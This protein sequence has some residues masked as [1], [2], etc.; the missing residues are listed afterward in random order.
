MV[1][2]Q[3]KFQRQQVYFSSIVKD[4]NQKTKLIKTEAVGT[5][6]KW[7]NKTKERTEKKKL[8]IAGQIYIQPILIFIKTFS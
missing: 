6:Q 7:A 5:E 8:Y 1:S 3:V 2:D 4:K